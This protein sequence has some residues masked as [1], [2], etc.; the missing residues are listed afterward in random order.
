MKSNRLSHYLYASSLFILIIL[1]AV[2]VAIS[3]ADVSIQALADKTTTGSFDFRNLV[4]VTG[5]Y[6]FLAL[7]SLLFSCSRMLSIRI[8]M[9]NIPKTCIPIKRNDLPEKVYFKVK[10][11]FEQTKMI[12]ESTLP[13]NEDIHTAGWAKPGTPLFEGLNFKQAVARTPSIVEKVA[14][15]IDPGYKRPL[16]CPVR[17][18]IEFL[19]REGIM[20]KQLGTVYVKG[21]EIARFSRDSLSQQQYI[22]IMKHLAGLLQYMGYN[23]KAANGKAA[24]QQT[25]NETWST[26][27]SHRTGNSSGY[28]FKLHHLVS[29]NSRSLSTN[30]SQSMKTWISRSTP[31]RQV[32]SDE[33]TAYDEDEVCQDIYELLTRDGR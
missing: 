33:F 15:S 14:I 1:T 30:D 21:Y 9:Q 20:D 29:R 17:Q 10:N 23:I 11:G 31:L 13:R 7:A 28:S 12:R 22:D 16:Y 19:I 32:F 6:V 25:G 18:Y 27:S 4:V 24:G 26:L 3:A 2:C 5:S 8:S